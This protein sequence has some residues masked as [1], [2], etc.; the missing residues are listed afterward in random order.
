[1]VIA[2]RVLEALREELTQWFPDYPLLLLDP[3]LSETVTEVRRGLTAAKA[4]HTDSPMT[5]ELLRV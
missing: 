4:A 2:N 5:N 1:M 3:E